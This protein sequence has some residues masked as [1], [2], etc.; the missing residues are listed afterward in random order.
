MEQSV[1]APRCVVC[2]CMEIDAER[3][4]QAI[5]DGART[6]NDVKLRTASGMG[7]CQGI[8][9]MPTIAAT[10]AERTGQS[11]AVLAP[12]TSRPPA[13]PIP[14]EALADLEG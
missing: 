2:R 13:R 9:C 12:M 10:L 5:D 14:L 7:L 6:V 11:L 4:Q 3:I 8:Y 1:D